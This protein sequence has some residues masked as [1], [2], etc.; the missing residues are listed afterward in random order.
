MKIW[1][2]MTL[3]LLVGVVTLAGCKK[4]SKA[5]PPP[6]AQAP[7]VEQSQAP[8]PPTQ[9][10][11]PPPQPQPTEPT[12]ATAPATPP[13]ATKPKTKRNKKT[14][15]KNT[16]P[17]P[18][19]PNKTVVDNGGT[20]ESGQL[21]AAIPQGEAT[22]Q[23]LSTTQLLDATENNLKSITRTLTNDE[24]E[25]V[26]QIRSY[27]QQSRLATGDGDTERAYNLAFKAHLLS[28]EL[29]KPK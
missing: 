20:G 16:P 21:S 25:M 11:Q 22:H 28:D 1:R 23:R 24:Q 4:K 5:A 6:Q 12:T 13:L 10:T 7:T 9:P 29:V 2:A 19:K 27:M 18:T 17:A 8:L 14:T 15:A 3:L 26:R